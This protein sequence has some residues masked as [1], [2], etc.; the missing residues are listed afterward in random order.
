VS[1][2]LLLEPIGGISG[3]LFLGAMADLGLDLGALQKLLGDRGLTGFAIE[4][5]RTE[6]HGI[7]GTRVTVRMTKA[8]AETHSHRHAH[9]AWSDIRLWL[10]QLPDGLSKRSLDI[11]GKLA[12]AEAKIHGVPEDEVEFH[13]VGATDSIVDIVGAA[14]ALDQLGNPHVISRPP[15]LGSGMIRSQHGVIPLPAPATLEVLSGLPT[16]LEGKGE[17]TTPTGAAILAA[18]ADFK[19][20]ASF[21]PERTGYGIGHS[22]FEDR[23][24]VLRAS[25]GSSGVPAEARG[26]DGG[27]AN[28]IY[29][30]ETHLDD[31]TPQLM[32]YVTERLL[33]AGALDVALSPLSMK[34]GRPGQRLTIVCRASDRKVLTDLLFRESTTLGVRAYPVERDELERR[35]IEVETPYGKLRI[36][37]GL[38]RGEVLNAAPEYDD[39]V[40]A[41]Q[42]HGVPLK[43]VMAAA[44]AAMRPR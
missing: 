26:S 3:D 32:A 37:L 24:N 20:P 38:L 30:L 40:A 9:R 19:L 25:L 6:E 1:S 7:V 16:L 12:R 5:E 44:V 31:L 17:L 18:C 23:P 8:V 22:R 28:Q 41:A 15:P 42:K 36:K 34:K 33:E 14:W 2:T 27:S 11:F 43:E 39:C 4:V 13:E 21:T 35:H 10:E 29:V